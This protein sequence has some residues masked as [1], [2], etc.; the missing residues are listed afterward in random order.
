M[1]P[2]LPLC[3]A[4]FFASIDADY[5]ISPLADA[6]LISL[7]QPFFAISLPHAISPRRR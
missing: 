6:A 4:I 1:M 2:P 5:A 7:Q 3:H